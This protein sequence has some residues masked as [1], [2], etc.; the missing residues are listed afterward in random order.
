MMRA[1]HGH[2][3]SRPKATNARRTLRKVRWLEVSVSSFIGLIACAM[4]LY[5]GGTWFDHSHPGHAFFENFL[6][7]LLHERSLSGQDNTLGA[8]LAT[9]GMVALVP[10]LVC[11]VLLVPEVVQIEARLW[12]ALRAVAILACLLLVTVPLLP[13]DRYGI[14]HGVAV[15][16]AGVP[17]TLALSA[18]VM[19][20]AR[21]EARSWAWRLLSSALVVAMLASLGLYVLEALLGTGVVRALPVLARCATVLLVTWLLAFARL[22]RTRTAT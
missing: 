10:G 6:C 14:F 8:T 3:A 4:A 11:F 19:K 17:A 15:L 5:P 1:A 12:R 20:I 9:I 7:D 22:V 16:G 21:T 13:S 18:M 2:T